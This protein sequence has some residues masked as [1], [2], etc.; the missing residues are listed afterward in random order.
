MRLKEIKDESLKETIL[1]EDE[2][3]ELEIFE[4]VNEMMLLADE[5]GAQK[6]SRELYEINRIR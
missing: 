3:I 4:I 5:M 1:T 6:R 2:Q